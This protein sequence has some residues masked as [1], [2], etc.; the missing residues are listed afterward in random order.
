M[1]DLFYFYG[2]SSNLEIVPIVIKQIEGTAVLDVGCGGGKYGFLMKTNWWETKSGS[3]AQPGSF[4]ETNPK[5]TVGI[6]LFFKSLQKARYHRT[7]HYYLQSKA[8][9]LPFKDKSFDTVISIDTIEHLE[10]KDIEEFFKELER[11]ARRKI[12]ITTLRK[13]KELT[14]AEYNTLPEEKKLMCDKVDVK[15]RD[16]RKYGYYLLSTKYNKDYSWGIFN[17]LYYGF[18][19]IYNLYFSKYLIAVKFLTR[20]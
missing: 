12:I 18:R 8:S 10:K 6:D 11:V 7:Y 9:E 3:L 14:P 16:F 20:K 2:H 13:T 17:F 5:L 15:A 19:K 4:E 1:D